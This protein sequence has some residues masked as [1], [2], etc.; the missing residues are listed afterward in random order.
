ML[1]CDEAD[2]MFAKRSTDVR[3]AVDRFANADAAYL[4]QQVERYPGIV[5][6]TTNQ[7]GNIDPAFLRRIRYEIEYPRPGVAERL[8]IWRKVTRAL[9]GEATATA[10]EKDLQSLA[11]TIDVT[12]AQIKTSVLGAVFIAGRH[13]QPLSAPHLLTAIDRELAKEGRSLGARERE[14]MLH[15]V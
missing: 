12:G 10:L 1:L 9:A 4:L 5:I 2:A 14:R 6:L 13:R 15:V 8:E 3:D 11:A 7:K